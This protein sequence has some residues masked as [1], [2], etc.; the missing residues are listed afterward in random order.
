MAIGDPQYVKPIVSEEVF[1]AIFPAENPEP[2]KLFVLGGFT[3]SLFS[4]IVGLFGGAVCKFGKK[5]FIP[6]KIDVLK[7]QDNSVFLID[8]ET[9]QKDEAS[10]Y[11]LKELD[12]IRIS[13]FRNLFA[14]ELD[15][16]LTIAPKEEVPPVKE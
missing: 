10:F 5:D 7:A 12:R 6:Q 2:N 16:D 1:K 9:Y 4:F 15:K 13:S 8:G 14:V 11:N 3:I